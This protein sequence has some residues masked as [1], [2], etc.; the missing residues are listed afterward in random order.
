MAPSRCIRDAQRAIQDC[1]RHHSVGRLHAG[2]QARQTEVLQRSGAGRGAHS[3]TQI[4]LK[5]PGHILMHTMDAHGAATVLK[6]HAHGSNTGCASM[7]SSQGSAARR[8]AA[9]ACWP[10]SDTQT[11]WCYRAGEGW[12]RRATALRPP[13]GWGPRGARAARRACWLI[14]CVC[15]PRCPPPNHLVVSTSGTWYG[16]SS[17][18][19][20]K[21]SMRALLCSGPCKGLPGQ[22][23]GARAGRARQSFA[24]A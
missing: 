18:I 5:Q 9:L 16:F 11:S 6:Y 8:N 14:C 22:P 20:R 17:T 1:E 19:C 12:C 13:A 23:P 10:P 2:S 7:S 21:R 4:N 15:A 3:G 24:C